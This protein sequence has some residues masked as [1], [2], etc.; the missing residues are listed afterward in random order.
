[1]NRAR[2]P[3]ILLIG[4]DAAEPSLLRA[5]IDRGVLPSLRNVLAHGTW[6]RVHSP[7][8]I[9]SGA[10]W[11]TFMTGKDPRAHEIYS[12]LPWEPASMSLVRLSTDHLTPFWQE[13][14]REGHTVGVLDVPFAPVAGL[15]NGIEIAEWGPH[16]RMRGRMLVSPPALSGWLARTVGEH[17]LGKGAAEVSGPGDRRGLLEV[18]ERCRIGARL[19]GMLAVR[20]L[21]EWHLDVLLAVFPEVHHASHYLWHTVDSRVRLSQA[22]SEEQAMPVPNLIDVLREVDRQIGAL[23][24]AAGENTMVLVFS[25]HG[26][27]ATEGIPAI[28][29]PL[30]QTMGLAA[31][32]PWRARTW[33]EQRRWFA[34]R[35]RPTIPVPLLRLYRRASRSVYRPPQRSVPLSY[36]WSKTTAFP[37]PTDQH[38]WLRVNLRGREAEGIVPPQRYD[39]VCRHLDRLLRGLATDR[40]DPVVADIVRIAG[41]IG[42]RPEHLPDLIVHW[43]DHALAGLLRLASPPITARATGMAFTGQHA[44]DGLFIFRPAAGS[45][46]NPGASL[47]VEDFP[48]LVR[49]LLGS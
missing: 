42:N 14:A 13:F 19:R 38:G 35:I 39:E 31:P 3:R 32:K 43:D 34:S 20:L 22:E 30:L 8:D 37:L 46:L 49:R 1:M 45:P 26:M 11:P 36:D 7:A 15:A 33:P 23:I 18:A 17:P 21:V 48:R 9:G 12:V 47:H 29:D 16:D 2:T 40:G 10:V 27:R 24:A 44:P 4:I 5:L 25:L 41:E 28:L 6:G